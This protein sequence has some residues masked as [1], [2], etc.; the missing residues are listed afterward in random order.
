LPGKNR[1][2][3]NEQGKQI[4][5]FFLLSFILK[6]SA[7]IFAAYMLNRAIAYLLIFS[8]I[9]TNFQRFVVFA[10]FE[11]NRNYIAANLCVNKNKPW[12]HCNGK[13]YFMRKIHEAEQK[14]ANDDRQSQKNLL[15]DSFYTT[16]TVI[17]FHSHLLQVIPIPNNRFA[18]PQAQSAIFHPPQLG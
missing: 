6:P 13:C 18:L 15:Q 4:L 8:L 2:E 12:L 5:N 7:Y 10:G 14:Q 16:V 1:P 3:L 9:A 17:K 11:M